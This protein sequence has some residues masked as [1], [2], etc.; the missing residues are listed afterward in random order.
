VPPPADP[1]ELVLLEN[2][3]YLVDD[4]RRA[5][6]FRRLKRTVGT[7][8]DAI[9]RT[10]LPLLAE[11]MTTDGDMA[12]Q[13]PPFRTTCRGPV[14]PTSCTGYQ[15]SA[16]CHDFCHDAVTWSNSSSRGESNSHPVAPTAF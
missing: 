9:L 1:F 14:P 12:R 15:F 7:R 6:V 3:A 11:V 13:P 8:P 2:C 10:P 16:D 5:T 4:R